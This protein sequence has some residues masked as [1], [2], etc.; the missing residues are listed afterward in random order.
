MKNA[1]E[2]FDYLGKA[3][4]ILSFCGN[5]NHQLNTSILKNSQLE[6][7]DSGA[8]FVTTK[9][10]HNVLVEIIENVTH[11]NM[12]NSFD[13]IKSMLF[14]CRT[15]SCY[16]IVTCNPIQSRELDRMKKRL[17]QIKNK[18]INELKENYRK[19]ILTTNTLQN[20]AGL[21][22]LD[23]A[24]KTENSFDYHF[25]HYSDDTFLYF[26]KARISA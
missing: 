1:I 8:S 11:Y 9:K 24:I 10:V 23:I 4:V 15:D 19:Q 16:E 12:R 6:L 26:F 7:N 25:K 21:G 14:L 5:F 22:I 20:E 2:I 18:S 17:E 13:N 3:N